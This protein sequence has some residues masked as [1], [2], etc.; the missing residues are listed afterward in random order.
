MRLLIAGLESNHQHKSCNHFGIK[1]V[2]DMLASLPTFLQTQATQPQSNLSFV[3]LAGGR[4]N[5]FVGTSES[6]E[7]RRMEAKVLMIDLEGF[8]SEEELTFFDLP[9]EPDVASQ[10]EQ[11]D[12]TD[13]LVTSP[14][15]AADQLDAGWKGS[16]C[17]AS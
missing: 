10:T 1:P 15:Q 14:Q 7:M 9:Q 4:Q 6:V 11:H 16:V 17:S 2:M 13:V 3:S 12:A 5:I 8:K